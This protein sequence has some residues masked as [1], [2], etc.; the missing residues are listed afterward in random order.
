MT[1]KSFYQFTFYDSLVIGGIPVALEVEIE[2]RADFTYRPGRPVCGP[3]YSSGGE[4]AEG[5]EIEIT[6]ITLDEALTYAEREAG[7]KPR[8]VPLPANDPLFARI[9]AWLLDERVDE[10]EEAARDAVAA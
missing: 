2:G 7:K 8:S 6:A 9:E 1:I 10:L 5:P 4:P 3:S